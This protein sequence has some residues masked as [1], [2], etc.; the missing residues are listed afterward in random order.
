[1]FLFVCLGTGV[2]APL[3]QNVLKAW[4]QSNCKCPPLAMTPCWVTPGLD[5]EFSHSPRPSFVLQMPFVFQC[6][7]WLRVFH[8]YKDFAKLD[9]G[10]TYKT[11]VPH[12]SG[13]GHSIDCIVEV[14]VCDH[15]GQVSS[16]S[17]SESSFL[18]PVW[19]H[20]SIPKYSWHTTT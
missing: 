6:D 9:S 17:V 13:I 4:R 16:Q 1:M 2:W 12:E 10:E 20:T 3:W 8:G 5:Q 18:R 15:K 7:S 14:S 11:V 19:T